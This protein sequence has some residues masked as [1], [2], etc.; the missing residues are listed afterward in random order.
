MT[1]AMLA[2]HGWDRLMWYMAT[3]PPAIPDE[4]LVT[5]GWEGF[6]ITFGLALVVVLI[7]AD[8]IRRIRRMN[9]RAEVRKKLDDED[10]V[11]AAENAARKDQTP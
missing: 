9:Y 2:V 11:A 6:A 10:A 4:S 8:M 5:P 7:I 1:A 3:T